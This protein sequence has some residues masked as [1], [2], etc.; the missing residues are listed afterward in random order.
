M[1]TF[2]DMT[3]CCHEGLLIINEKVMAFSD[4]RKTMDLRKREKEH[5]ER[6]EVCNPSLLA[7]YLF[8]RSVSIGK[9]VPYA[10]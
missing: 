4:N 1:K 8:C 2:I 9:D 10:R 5:L 3:T 6:C 7:E